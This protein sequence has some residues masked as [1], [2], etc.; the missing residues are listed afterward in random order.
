MNYETI[1]FILIALTTLSFLKII[2]MFIKF[3]AE[4]IV[5]R[6]NTWYKEDIKRVRLIILFHIIAGIAF[7]MAF[8]FNNK[9]VGEF[10][11]FKNKLYLSSSIVFTLIGIGI[12]TYSWSTAFANYLIGNPKKKLKEINPTFKIKEDLKI[13][14]EVDS[15]IKLN[16]IDKK[17]KNNMINFLKGKRVWGKINITSTLQNKQITYFPLFDFLEKVY[18]G[19]IRK[20]NNDRQKEFLYIIMAFFKK[21]GIHINEKNIQASFYKWRY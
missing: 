1:K 6:K 4:L 15:L 7:C 16:H 2:L 21:G 13:E 8:Y 9:C 18:E 14:D 3:L 5:K 10:I 19:G 17:S 12:I 11:T 20:I